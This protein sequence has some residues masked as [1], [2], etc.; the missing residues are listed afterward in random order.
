MER[1]GRVT[2]VMVA[3]MIVG[4]ITTIGVDDRDVPMGDHAFDPPLRIE[5]GE[6]IG[7][8]HLG[9]TAVVFVEQRAAGGWLVAEGPV[10][11]GQGLLRAQRGETRRAD[12]DRLQ[13]EDR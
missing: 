7:V 5:R 10:R 2:V 12:S 1:L 6:E 13:G 3:A 8:F 11:Y 9:S 4:R